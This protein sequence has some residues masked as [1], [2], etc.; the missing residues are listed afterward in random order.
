MNR[1]LTVKE[2][3]E[4]QYR[5]AMLT[6]SDA[7]V[8]AKRLCLDAMQEVPTSGPGASLLV[9]V[10]ALLQKIGTISDMHADGAIVGDAAD[11][12]LPPKYH[13]AQE[14]SS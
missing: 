14:E 9:G 5:S 2:F 11:W 8:N 6:I 1:S 3:N 13:S 10:E 7:A 4:A 12:L